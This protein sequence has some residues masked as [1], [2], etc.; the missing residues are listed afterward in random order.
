LKKINFID[1]NKQYE[2]HK[3]E[4][5]I[6]MANVLNHGAF[7]QGPE[8]KELEQLLSEYTGS[9]A[10]TV[11]NGT[12]ALFISLMA[13]GIGP[14]DEV[15]TPSFTWVSTVE[16]IRLVGAKPVYIEV[17]PE[18]FNINEDDIK[19]MITPRTK[20]IMPVSIFGRCPNLNIIK[21]LPEV[22]NNDIKIL[23]DAAQSFGA[24][25]DGLMSCSVADI[26]TTSFFP[27]KPLGCYGDGGAIFTNDENLFEK[28]SMI[29]KHGQQGRYNYKTIGVNSRLDTLQAAVLISK[30]KFFEKEISMRNKVA[31]IYNELLSSTNLIKI[32]SIPDQANRSVWA[33]YTIIL[34]D[35]VYKKRQEI[36]AK[37][38]EKN[39][40]TALYYPA[41]LHLQKPYF[42]SEAFLPIT[43][44]I[45]DRV[46]SLPMH[47]YLEKV[48]IEYIS[49]NLM[50][51][52]DGLN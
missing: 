11:A 15:I 4:I 46:I 44:Y 28:I 3:D 16:A 41:A 43:E 34:D 37:M 10:L 23:E 6:S 29:S 51:I 49:D 38:K 32:P 24:K 8:V 39:I 31:N 27:A 26:S 33:Q 9:N 22:K 50:K 35:E 40:P 47:P 48:E 42:D 21:N 18:T 14:G 25:S 2:L 5:D 1:V 36:M 19:K 52:L 45:A 30:L 12:D 13:L 17:R 7:I 20:V